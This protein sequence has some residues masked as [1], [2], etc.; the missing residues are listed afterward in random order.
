MSQFEDAQKVQSELSDLN[1]KRDVKERH[2][3]TLRKD[4][5]DVLGP[6]PISLT[7][8]KFPKPPEG[9]YLAWATFLVLISVFV[10]ALLMPTALMLI[11][12]VGVLVAFVA[13]VL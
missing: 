11:L 10:A 6:P 12:G 1:K 9:G 4:I 2:L 3:K 5:W 7:K 8:I 13:W